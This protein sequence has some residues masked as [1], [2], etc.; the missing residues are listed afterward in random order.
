MKTT[1][2][3]FLCLFLLLKAVCSETKA[4]VYA[5]SQ[6]NGKSDSCIECSIANASYDVDENEA[7]YTTFNLTASSSDAC[8]YQNLEFSY[9]ANAGDYVGIII[10]DDNLLSLD[11]TK[12]GDVALTTF[13]NHISNND[14]KKSD[15][16]DIRL[17]PGSTTQY[18]IGFEATNNFDEIEI[19]FKA[20][21]ERTVSNLRIYA[22]YYNPNQLP[23]EVLQ[24]FPNPVKNENINISID[25][26]NEKELQVVVMDISRKNYYS[27]T[28]MTKNG[29]NVI[30]L[31]GT[32]ELTPGAYLVVA[33]YNNNYY[34]K[35]IIVE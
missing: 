14:S 15:Q 27:K 22:A 5:N 20:G 3:I 35:K 12:L 31:D 1:Q 26:D 13:Y 8:I 10:E 6:I 16:Y 2:L 18:I 28:I 34:K 30:V 25:D 19:K 11:A 23:V 33:S 9:S 32:S 21:K 29:H 24:I 4:Q 7:N 17:K